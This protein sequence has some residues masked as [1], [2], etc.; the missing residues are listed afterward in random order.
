MNRLKKEEVK[1][2][3]Q[4]EKGLSDNQLELL[5]KIMNCRENFEK[6]HNS[7][8]GILFPEE[9][10]FML[11]DNVDANLR[12]HGENPMSKDYQ[13]KVNAKRQKLGLQPLSENGMCESDDSQK[14]SQNLAIQFLV[15]KEVDKSKILGMF[16]INNS[17]SI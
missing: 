12:K 16:E 6:L 17:W 9:F 2:Q 14:Y 5:Q 11:D 8:H 15:N 7:I 4:L 3:K 13:N 1:K 10:D